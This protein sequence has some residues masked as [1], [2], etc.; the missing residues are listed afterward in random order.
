MDDRRLRVPAGT[1][2]NRKLLAPSTFKE[3]AG[4]D[5][6]GRRGASRPSRADGEGGRRGSAEDGGGGGSPAAGRSGGGGLL[7]VAARAIRG[8]T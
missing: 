3:R 4:A 5:R 8:E 1:G 6:D 2:T 7:R